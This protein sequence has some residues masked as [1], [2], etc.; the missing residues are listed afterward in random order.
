VEAVAHAP[1]ARGGG[2]MS[3]V[4]PL[5]EA[6]VRTATPLLI[7]SIGET[8]SERAGVINI[9]LEGC[10]LAGAYAAFAVGAV[11]PAAGFAAATAAG[12][13][14]GVL[15]A[16]FS[17]AWRRDQIIVGAALTILAMGVTGTLFRARD[18]GTAL[19]VET[20]PA[21]PLPG[22]SDIPVIGSA[23]FAQPAIAYLAF[24]LV[25]ATWW[26][27]HRTHSGLSIRAVGDAPDAARAAGVRVP[28]VQ[29]CAVLFGSA[30][31]GLAGGALVLAQAGTFAEGMSAGRGFLAIAIVALGRWRP[32]GVAIAS[33]VFGGAMALQFVVQAMGWRVRY[34]LVLMIPYLLT[35]AALGALGRGAAPAMLGRTIPRD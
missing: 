18:Q 8:V 32:V 34:E 28:A 6:A 20:Q 23:F 9:G 3:D 27:L 35:L 29:A 12:L 25:P 5:L 15:L 30:L 2:V 17:I 7:A 21:T 26:F 1:C 16:V 31:G 33:L 11:T 10:I 22:L 4:T 14:I 24:A 19:V 13:A